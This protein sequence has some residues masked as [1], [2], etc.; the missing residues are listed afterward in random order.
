MKRYLIYPMD[1]DTRAR[2]LEDPVE[3]WHEEPK[4]NHLEGRERLIESLKVELGEYEF[5]TKLENFKDAGM[6]PF[7][8]V[9]YHNFLYRQAR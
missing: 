6:A 8:I 9:S 7:S 5:E 2:L 4:K 1:F 3:S